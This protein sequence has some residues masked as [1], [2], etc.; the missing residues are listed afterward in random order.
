M[1]SFVPG[2][3]AAA[4]L[5]TGSRG[6]ENIIEGRLVAQ[7]DDDILLYQPKAAPLTVLTA[8]TRRKRR[9]GNREFKWME[10]DMYPRSLELSTDSIVGDT[11]IDVLAGQG[12]RAKAE[13]VLLNTRTRESVLVSS[14]AT[15][16]VTVVRGIGG[17]EV[18]MVAGDQLVITRA[19]YPDG[20]DIGTLK[21]IADTEFYNFTENIRRAFG[22]T[23]RDL[24]TE[25][26]G[27]S[28]EMTETK[29][30]AIEHSKDIE[31]AFLFGRRHTRTGANNHEQTF[32][33]GAEY[34]VSDN[35]WD[36]SGVA[37][38]ERAFTEFAEEAMRWGPGGYLHGNS[39]KVLFHSSRWGTELNS[40][41][42]DRV[43]YRPQDQI[44]G[45]SIGSIQ[46]PHGIVRLVHD[47]L[48][49]E[50]HPDMAML[51]D[52]GNIR[53]AYMKGRDTRLLDNRQ[54]NGIDGEQFE[55][56][57]DCGAEFKDSLSH[58]ILK[59]LA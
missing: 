25:L 47:P 45:L 7:M 15:D 22:F 13:D 30:Q 44:V 10:K 35:V 48:L 40:W 51:L 39:T 50:Y 26:Y 28:D 56:H 8:R 21:S 58:A 23:G 17:A 11:V 52:L 37:L 54:G 33:G 18:D 32:T 43:E 4:T 53:Y 31:Y 2:Q 46:T 16:A 36:V 41:Y 14:I 19:V 5:V 1:G 38:S 9:V 27:G 3:R 59:G 34:F 49:D 20:A 29:W 6:P 24:A 55:F 42:G 12:V 57:T